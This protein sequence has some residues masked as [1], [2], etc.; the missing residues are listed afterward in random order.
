MRVRRAIPWVAMLV[1]APALAAAPDFKAGEWATSYRMEVT[2]MPFPMP[3]IAVKR[4]ACLTP[5]RYVPDNAQQGQDCKV[6]DTRVEGN[7]VTWTMRC[8]AREGTIEGKGRITYRG[9]R[10]DGA[11]DATLV[12]ADGPGSPLRYRYTMEGQ[13]LGACK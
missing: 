7:T 12:A 10:Y 6:S 11:M 1:A 8:A 13:R 3:P 5:E 4:S 2:G 9:E